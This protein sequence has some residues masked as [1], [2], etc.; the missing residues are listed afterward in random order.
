ML[1]AFKR[2]FKRTMLGTLS[3]C[4]GR[5]VYA[6]GGPMTPQRTVE[7]RVKMIE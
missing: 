5:G 4:A 7:F 6:W 1:F 3:A 2:A